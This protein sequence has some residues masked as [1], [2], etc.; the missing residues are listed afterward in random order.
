MTGSQIEEFILHM[1]QELFALHMCL[2]LVAG[3]M[4]A[5]IRMLE[6]LQGEIRSANPANLQKSLF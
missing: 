2:E 6:S 3:R 4:E 1:R 5:C